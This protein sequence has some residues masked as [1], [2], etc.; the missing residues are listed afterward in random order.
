MCH[1]DCAEKHNRRIMIQD[2]P[3]IKQDPILKITNA[4]RGGGTVKVVERLP[5][6]HEPLSSTPELPKNKQGYVIAY[7]GHPG[8][9]RIKGQKIPEGAPYLLHFLDPLPS[10]Y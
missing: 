1:H 9:D 8:V 6:K 7:L 5:S 4:K 2:G 3:G 10:P